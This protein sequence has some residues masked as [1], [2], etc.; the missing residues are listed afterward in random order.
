[1]SGV[2]P[3]LSLGERPCPKSR[4]P[5]ICL[6]GETKLRQLSD[7]T[8]AFSRSSGEAEFATLLEKVLV[9]LRTHCVFDGAQRNG[10]QTNPIECIDWNRLRR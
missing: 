3:G 10:V 1:M 2:S 6:A 5:L 9:P 4:V 8:G 7:T